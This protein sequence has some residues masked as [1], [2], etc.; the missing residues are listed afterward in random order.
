MKNFLRLSHLWE[1]SLLQSIYTT[2]RK[3]VI[4]IMS[5]KKLPWISFCM[6]W[7]MVCVEIAKKQ[8]QNTIFFVSNWPGDT[9]VAIVLPILKICKAEVPEAKK[10]LFSLVFAW[11]SINEIEKREIIN[12]WNFGNY[13]IN[14]FYTG[15]SRF[16]WFWFSRV[17]I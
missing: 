17:L 15:I 3:V 12:S 14:Y 2:Q 5:W 13:Q 11:Q 9:L 8:K 10:H 16:L 4:V 6:I 1:F 7:I